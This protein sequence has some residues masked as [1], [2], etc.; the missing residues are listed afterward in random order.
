MRIVL[1]TINVREW[2]AHYTDI[3][4]VQQIEINSRL[5]QQQLEVDQITVE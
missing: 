2:I 5:V 1:V 3:P 4:I